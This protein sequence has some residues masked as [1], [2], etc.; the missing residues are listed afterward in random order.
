MF[1]QPIIAKEFD[2]DQLIKDFTVPML[3]LFLTSSF[4]RPRKDID[5]KGLKSFVV[6]KAELVMW[7]V[8]QEA[9]K[10]VRTRAQRRCLGYCSL[11]CELSSYDNNNKHQDTR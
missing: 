9:H 7:S 5:S 4:L 2:I 10:H 6:K 8:S 11:E 1:N 3:R